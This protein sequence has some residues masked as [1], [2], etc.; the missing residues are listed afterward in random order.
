MAA[1]FV[2][3]SIG[4]VHIQENGE[5]L[6]NLYVVADTGTPGGE[7]TPLLRRAAAQLQ[8]YLE[9]SRQVFDLP[10]CPAGTPF[11]QK[12]W[13]ALR[14]IPY[15]ETRTYGEIAKAIGQPGAARAVGMANNRNPLLILIPCHRVVGADGS[16]TGYAAGLPQKEKLLK[17]E[18][19]GKR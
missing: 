10:L 14:H 6:T 12:V 15:G 4:L 9:G 13:T 1:C 17:L 18:Q 16:L 8:E 19:E 5:G 11:Q 2:E 7:D 3:T